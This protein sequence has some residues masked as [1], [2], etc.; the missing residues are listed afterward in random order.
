MS[1]PDLPMTPSKNPDS[2]LRKT[3]PC[4]EFPYYPLIMM[5]T[6]INT[7]SQNLQPPLNLLL[8][9]P[10]SHPTSSTSP[11]LITFMPPIPAS[12]FPMLPMRPSTLSPWILFHS[13][14]LCSTL[15][16]QH[17]MTTNILPLHIPR[18]G[19][20]LIPIAE[21][22]ESVSFRFCCAFVAHYTCFLYG[23]EFGKGF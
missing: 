12:T 14:D 8:L 2:T 21:T 10:R 3:L 22:H 4:P 19:E 16:Q 11:S 18:R 20:I 6:L 13:L 1:S 7:S 17:R 15:S 9:H 5:M 23:G